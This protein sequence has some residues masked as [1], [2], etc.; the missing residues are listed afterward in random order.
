MIQK[1]LRGRKS[2]VRM[3]SLV[4]G[5]YDR[6]LSKLRN[7]IE[8]YENNRRIQAA[9]RVSMCFRKY[10][11]RVRVKRLADIKA[12]IDAVAGQMDN[13]SRAGQIKTGKG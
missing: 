9:I 8:L 5:L 11:S 3:K 7:D 1:H 12:G 13:V 10:M 2:R 4:E 6:G